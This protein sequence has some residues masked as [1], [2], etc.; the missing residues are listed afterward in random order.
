M[1]PKPLCD[2]AMADSAIQSYTT[3]SHRRADRPAQGDLVTIAQIVRPHG[4]KG[5]LVAEIITDFP[6]RFT[7]LKDIFLCLP[8]GTV[9]Q[10]PLEGYRFHQGRIVLKLHNIDT[11]SSAEN[12]RGVLVCIHTSE[13]ITLAPG[14]YYEFQLIGCEVI[15]DLGVRLGKVKELMYTGAAPLLVILAEDGKEYMI[16]L[17]E[18]ICREIDIQSQKITVTPPE[19]LL[20]L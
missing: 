16:P 4:I 7:R 13:L 1:Q 9:E 14:A 5:E 11:R 20:E 8:N 18:D 17:V 2:L 3:Q 10:V 15:T 6:D 19:G 12:L